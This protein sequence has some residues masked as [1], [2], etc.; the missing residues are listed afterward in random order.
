MPLN[1]DNVIK[2][3]KRMGQLK[4][5]S[6][7]KFG[8]HH[9]CDIDVAYE[10]DGVFVFGELKLAG[11]DLPIGQAL[12]LRHLCQ[13]IHNSGNACLIFVAEHDTK[14]EEIIDVGECIVTEIMYSWDGKIKER[15]NINK[16]ANYVVGRYLERWKDGQVKK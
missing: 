5:F 7:M 16:P 2:F 1:F 11:V 4:D 10:K 9:P 8:G 6:S 3:P 14:P 13:A 15:S 12:L